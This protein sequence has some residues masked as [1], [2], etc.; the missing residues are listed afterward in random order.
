MGFE[1]A[2]AP[3]ANVSS[4]QPDNST[5]FRSKSDLLLLGELQLPADVVLNFK[6]H[7][8]EASQPRIELKP[9]GPAGDRADVY[10]TAFGAL[11]TLD[12]SI[13]APPSNGVT[14]STDPALG[15]AWDVPDHN[16]P[17]GQ[18]M[19][20][21]GTGARACGCLGLLSIVGR[22]RAPLLLG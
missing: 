11:Q 9:L 4:F 15:D 1:R 22:H 3:G 18:V 2:D 14:N 5:V 17:S 10:E 8:L 13:N 6:S 7:Q 12:T 20:R 19:G 21:L 16:K